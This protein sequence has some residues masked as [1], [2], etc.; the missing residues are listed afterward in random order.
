MRTLFK[1]ALAAYG[2]SILLA[3]QA[4]AV[5]DAHGLVED[6][7]HAAEEHAKGGL[8]QF[9]PTFFPTQIFWLA[10]IFGVMYI[11]FARKT[12][13]EI[14]SVL[15]NRRDHIQSDLDTAEKLREEAEEAHRAY[16][17]ALDKARTEA[18]DLFADVE[19]KVKD[20]SS[21]DFQA[22]YERSSKEIKAAEAE[23]E[24]A[25]ADAF[26]EMSTIAAEIASQAAE[27]IVGISTDINQA[28]TVIESL[29]K[30]NKRAA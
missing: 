13:P 18:S 30:N 23:I 25:K 19:K 20:K 16:D 2:S 3:S 24:K 28:K 1:T 22:F 4:F 12:L 11:F 29:H 9:D 8:P 7:H 17:E 27:K 26:E 5:E 15:E 21:K 6:A 10:V 14:S